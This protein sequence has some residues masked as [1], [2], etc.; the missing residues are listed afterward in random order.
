MLDDNDGASGLLSLEGGPNG[1]PVNPETRV[2]AVVIAI[3]L[4]FNL[5]KLGSSSL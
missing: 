2:A 5:D 4:T 1:L 3:G